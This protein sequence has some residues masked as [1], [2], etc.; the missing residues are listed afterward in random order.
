MF[1]LLLALETGLFYQPS[2]VQLAGIREE[3]RE[4]AA[5]GKTN[6]ESLGR[7]KRVSLRSQETPRSR[8]IY[9]TYCWDLQDGSSG[10]WTLWWYPVQKAVNM[11]MLKLS[12]FR[13]FIG[14]IS[15]A[16]VCGVLTADFPNIMA[17]WVAS[18]CGNW[19]EIQLNVFFFLS[20]LRTGKQQA[21]IG[22]ALL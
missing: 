15:L 8:V 11:G 21:K 13:S 22:V 10:L 18:D 9:F 14:L 5:R 2:A 4:R 19:L 1:V 3:C 12:L 6:P 16:Y 20:C 7:R 17:L